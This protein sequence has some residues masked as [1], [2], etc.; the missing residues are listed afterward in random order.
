MKR[1]FV[2]AAFCAIG[3]ASVASASK[4]LVFYEKKAQTLAKEIAAD[5]KQMMESAG[6][7]DLISLHQRRAQVLDMIDMV[8]ARMRATVVDVDQGAGKIAEIENQIA[9]THKYVISAQEINLDPEAVLK[10]EKLSRLKLELTGLRQT[11]SD[12]HPQVLSKKK[13]IDEA[14]TQLL[15]ELETFGRRRVGPNAVYQD[16]QRELSEQKVK[17]GQ[18]LAK[19]KILEKQLSKLEPEASALNV[20]THDLQRM[21]EA[22]AEKKK[23]YQHYRNKAEEAGIAHAVESQGAGSTEIPV[24]FVY[25]MPNEKKDL[26]TQFDATCASVPRVG[27]TVVHPAGHKKAMVTN[28][29]HNFSKT[30]SERFVQNITVILGESASAS[31]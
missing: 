13:Q 2:A 12:K 19:I 31:P 3:I 29:Y 11:Y 4:V 30:D 28:V 5:E 7:E 20:K 26:H 8:R 6:E 27:D 10:L 18:Q 1:T 15:A 23:R 17:R 14:K 25:L 9:Q 22:L 21:R 16:L 24:R